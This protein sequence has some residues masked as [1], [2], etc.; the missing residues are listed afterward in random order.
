MSTKNYFNEPTLTNAEYLEIVKYHPL[1]LKKY[2]LCSR[3]MKY[4]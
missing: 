2:Q 4:V 1:E 3:V